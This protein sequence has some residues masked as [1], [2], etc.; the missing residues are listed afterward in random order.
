MACSKSDVARYPRSWTVMTGQ[1][2]N[3]TWW[4]LLLEGHTLIDGGSRL[5]DL[6]SAELAANA[7][8]RVWESAAPTSIP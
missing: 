6:A 1:D 7:A 5:H 3:D 4:W 2:A 8:L